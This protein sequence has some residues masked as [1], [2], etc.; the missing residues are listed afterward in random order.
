VLCRFCLGSMILIAVTLTTRSPG[1]ADE[2]GTNEPKLIRDLLPA[3]VNIFVKKFEAPSSPGNEAASAA[4]AA[5]QI[6]GYVGSGFVIDPSGLLVTNYHVVEGA[7]EIKVTFSDDSRLSAGM[8]SASRMADLALLKVRADHPLPSAHWGDSD[9]LQVGDQVIAAGNPF[10]IG[11]TVTTGIVSALNRNIHDSPYDDFIQTDAPINHG[12]SGGPLF[13][14][15][16]EVVGVDSD[17]ISPTTGSVG[18]GFAQP[19]N[20]ASFVI[21]RLGKYGW[22]EPGWIGVK[23]QQVTQRMAEAMGEAQPQGSIVAWVLANGPAKKAGLEVGDVIRR[24]DGKMPSDDRAL[25]RDI[26]ATQVGKTV[27]LTVQRKGKDLDLPVTVEAWP[28]EQWEAKDAPLAVQRPKV[29][30]PPNLGLSLSP[31]TE[32]DR[33]RLDVEKGLGGVLVTSVVP[34]TDA[35]SV[36]MANDDV[37]LRVG[38]NAVAAPEEVQS[39]VDAARADK[40]NFVLMLVLP[41]VRKVPGPEWMALRVTAASG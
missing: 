30:I 29:T 19:S 3:V 18:L 40:R 9:T 39:A 8:V 17:I 16:G 38:N 6:K 20:I 23:V 31:L 35:A 36:G 37:I 22:I 25:L 11:L 28:R 14:L 13:N 32:A 2:S 12:N 34:G 26:V 15:R 33:T 1:L 21:D 41:K 5:Q 27:T 7:F 10:G 24:Y 4:G